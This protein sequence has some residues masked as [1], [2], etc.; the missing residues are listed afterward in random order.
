MGFSRPCSAHQDQVVGRFHEGGARELLDLCLWQRCFSP[1]DTSQI[2]M[3]REARG[4][5]LV[6]QTAHLAI[7]ELGADQPVQPGFG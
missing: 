3:H 1:V 4:L 6:T 2:P 7:R 5:E